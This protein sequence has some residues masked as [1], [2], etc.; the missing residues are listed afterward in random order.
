MESYGVIDSLTPLR[1]PR[2]SDPSCEALSVSNLEASKLKDETDFLSTVIELVP[3]SPPCEAL[4]V[5]NLEASKLKDETD[6]LSTV[7]ELV[8]HSPPC[9]AT[10]VAKVPDNCSSTGNKL[11]SHS[12]AVELVEHAV[13]DASSPMLPLSFADV[14]SRG[15]NHPD[16]QIFFLKDTRSIA[17]VLSFNTLNSRDNSYAIIRKAELEPPVAL[18]IISSRADVAASNTYRCN[19]SYI[20]WH[21]HTI[22]CTQ[23]AVDRDK[24]HSSPAAAQ[25][26]CNTTTTILSRVGS[27]LS[28][29][30][31]SSP[32]SSPLERIASWIGLPGTITTFDGRESTQDQN[33]HHLF[34]EPAKTN[35]SSNAPA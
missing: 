30:M 16:L 33:R 29:H 12:P 7:I 34:G 35:T 28:Q 11:T 2:L 24:Q 6:F 21:F 27:V 10:L 31:T 5:S 26:K 15:S 32:S 25:A 1:S 23:I 17:T 19:T 4:S 9:E 20:Q 8:P 3:H 14:V 22:Y 18:S 13:Q